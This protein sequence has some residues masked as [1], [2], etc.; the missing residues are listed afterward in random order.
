M[1]SYSCSY[2]SIGDTNAGN[3]V[4]LLAVV[5]VVIMVVVMVVMPPMPM[6][7]MLVI[8]GFR[9][10]HLKGLRRMVYADTAK[11]LS[12]FFANLPRN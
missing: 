1:R 2:R 8:F 3:V 9:K 7:M 11:S 12:F 10:E 4:D 5:L 6:V